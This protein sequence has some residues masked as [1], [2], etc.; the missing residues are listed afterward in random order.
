METALA[1]G[2]DRK[3]RAMAT[4]IYSM[5]S[6]RFGVLPGQGRQKSSPQGRSN[7]REKEI[8]NIRAEL[9]RLTKAYKAATEEE[10]PAL[11]ELRDVLRERLK[12]LRR[13]E[14][15]RRKR[16]ERMKSRAQ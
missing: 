14:N 16:K 2:V 4:I 6:D 11:A 10:K 15:N 3:V 7:R 13:A 9:K 5:G 12:S 8:S 1:G